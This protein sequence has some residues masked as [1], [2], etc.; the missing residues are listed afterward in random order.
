MSST[1]STLTVGD[2]QRPIAALVDD[3]NAPTL[4]W[5]GGFRSDM[6][7]SKAEALAAF[8]RDRGQ[9]VV[10]FDYSGHGQSGGSFEAGTISRWSEEAVAVIDAMAPGPVVL[11][12]SSMGGWMALLVCRALAARG[13][14]GR[15]RGLV[16]VAPAPDFTERL[17]LPGFSDEMRTALDRDGSVA[18]P[19][20][21]G[22]PLVI[23]RDLIEDGRRHLV[24]DHHIQVDAPVR[25][26][27]GMEDPDVPWTHALALVDRLVQDDVV[28]TLVRDGDHRLSRPA[29][30]ERILA[31]VAGVLDDHG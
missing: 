6:S 27:Q 9:R 18:I 24:L 3:G 7:G 11:V 17:M 21:Y 31:A 8:G 26:V 13:E 29:D 12:G 2:D 25:I 1:A 16:L 28:V 23:T 4:V 22:D 10:R 5:L 20:A 15:I 14:T 19:S 30:I